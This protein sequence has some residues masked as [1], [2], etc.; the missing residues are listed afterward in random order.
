[1][2]VFNTLCTLYLTGYC[3][4]PMDEEEGLEASR[5]T[6][7]NS[8][9]DSVTGLW[10]VSTPVTDNRKKTP[11]LLSEYTKPSVVKG[12]RLKYVTDI[13]KGLPLGPLEVRFILSSRGPG[14]KDFTEV[15]DPKT[16]EVVSSFE[17]F[18][19]QLYV[20]L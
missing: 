6:E 13:V 9:L 19:N 8:S 3:L 10:V 14:D 17:M 11:K 15:A 2:D 1:M 4:E 18:L 7:G 20:I 16:K 12:I 5:T